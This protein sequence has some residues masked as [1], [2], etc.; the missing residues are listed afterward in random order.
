MGRQE[1][2]QQMDG[3]GSGGRKRSSGGRSV[4]AVLGLQALVGVMEP[5]TRVSGGL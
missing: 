5:L 2:G 1:G 3:A 4:A